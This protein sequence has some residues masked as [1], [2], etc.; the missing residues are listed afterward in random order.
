MIN[1]SL[2]LSHFADAK[3]CLGSTKAKQDSSIGKPEQ[4]INQDEGK[5]ISSTGDSENSPKMKAS[6]EGFDSLKELV[7]L[8][9]NI[10]A[11]KSQ[12]LKGFVRLTQGPEEEHRET[13][14]LQT[15]KGFDPKAYKFLIKAGYNP[16]DRDTLGKLSPEADGEQ[17]YGLNATQKM[18]REKRHSVQ[19]SRSGLWFT[20]HNPVRIAIKRASTNYTAEE[21]YSSTNDNEG[22][23]VER[24][25]VFNRLGPH[26]RSKYN[27]AKNQRLNI[28]AKPWKKTRESQAHQ[29]L[30]SL[31]PS[32]MKRCSN[33]I[34]SC[35]K[36]LKVKF[37][38]IILTKSQED[39]DDDE[40]SIASSYHI[41]CGEGMIEDE[42]ATTYHIT[43]SEEDSVEEE[44]AKIAP[45]ELE[46]GV[47]ATV[48]ELKE[49]N[50]GDVENHRP[51]YISALLT[52]D[53]EKA[54]VE[55][56]HE[57]KDVFA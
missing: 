30:Q 20:P 45:P 36:V 39:E 7:L 46:E 50:L 38:T 21:E 54:Y 15:A 51:I 12:P 41:S 11:R 27:K 17:V 56:L 14:N 49:I 33:L 25:S 31:I 3:Y 34:I 35:N 52:D 47:K 48:D 19:S 5:T 18:L 55:L 42:V 16:Q 32:S 26:R 24:I 2:K 40:E 37:Q 23:K 22:K 8:L 13:S 1:P 28:P 9:I 53:E 57:F 44:D 29:K 4:R 10:D 6:L 43:L